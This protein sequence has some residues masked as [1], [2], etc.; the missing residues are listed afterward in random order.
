MTSPLI[1]ATQTPA[2]H[3]SQQYTTTPS[4]AIANSDINGKVKTT[5]VEIAPSQTYTP[6]S[7]P[8]Q[9][10]TDTLATSVTRDN[11]VLLL[12]VCIGGAVLVIITILVFMLLRK[13]SR[14]R[15]AKI[16]R[17]YHT[18]CFHLPN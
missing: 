12:G 6:S 18:T 3:G 16:T 7:L 8:G 10:K 2:I 1:S 14:T 4:I 9:T 5:N 11:V 13:N 15:G 17:R